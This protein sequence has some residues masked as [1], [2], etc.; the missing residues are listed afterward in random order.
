[1][2][3]VVVVCEIIVSVAVVVVGESERVVE[4]EAGSTAHV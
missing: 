4:E 1:M 2:V 3:A